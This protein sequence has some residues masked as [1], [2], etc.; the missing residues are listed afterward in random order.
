M[1]P[2]VYLTQLKNYRAREQESKRAG[3]T[4]WDIHD[5]SYFKA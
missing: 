3:E 4:G 1:I 2:L 5:M